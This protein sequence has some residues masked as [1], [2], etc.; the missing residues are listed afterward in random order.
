[1][2]SKKLPIA[3][4]VV[5]TVAL[6]GLAGAQAFEPLT[7][8]SGHAKCWPNCVGK[9]CCD[10]YDGKPLP[11]AVGANCFDCAD[12][13]PKPL[14]CLPAV[15]AA[16]CCDDFCPKPLPPTCYTTAKNLRCVPS[17]LPPVEKDIP[18]P[19]ASLARVGVQVIVEAA[20]RPAFPAASTD[21]WE[22]R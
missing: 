17:R 12:Y 9:F 6:T 10:D 16:F 14:P 7:W 4:A 19:A 18:K 11:C 1:M 13:C 5:L 2:N 8:L 22:S 3:L 21:A 15:K 20:D